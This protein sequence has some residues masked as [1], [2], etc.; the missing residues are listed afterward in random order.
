MYPNPCGQRARRNRTT[1]IPFSFIHASVIMM[2]T[3]GHAFISFAPLS[4]VQR[5]KHNDDE[6]DCNLFFADDREVLAEDT[7]TA[8]AVREDETSSNQVIDDP[9]GGCGEGFFASEDGNYCVFDYDAAAE[10]FGTAVEEDMVNDAEQ[11]WEELENRNASRKKFGL[12]PLT[13]EEFVALQGQIHIIEARQ[14][15]KLLKEQEKSAVAAGVAADNERDQRLSP[16]NLLKGFM[17]AVMQD[18]CE[19]NYDCQRPEVCCDFGFNKRCCEGGRTSR[20]L[21]QEYAMVPVHSA[22][23][24][25]I[26]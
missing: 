15:E 9:T 19:S 20:Q 5:T 22:V 23:S 25:R 16:S 12:A 8:V 2:L 7:T 24:T 26:E 6:V 18:T 14:Q 4:S 3:L 10:A 11:Y 13:P 1:M 17:G 21:K